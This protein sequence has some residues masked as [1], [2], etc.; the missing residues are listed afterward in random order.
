MLKKRN[1]LETAPLGQGWRHPLAEGSA[2]L[3]TR[4]KAILAMG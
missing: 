4:R 1:G 2:A 3:L